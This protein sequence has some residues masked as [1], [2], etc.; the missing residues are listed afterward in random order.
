MRSNLATFSILTFFLV[1]VE[2]SLPQDQSPQTSVIHVEVVGLRSDKGEVYCALYSSAAGFPKDSRK[3]MQRTSS[4]ISSKN[5]A[6]EFS[7]IKPGT[8]AISAFHDENSN[9]K[10]DTNFLG[11]PREGLGASNDA[12]GHLGPPKFNAAAFQFSGGRLNLKI[13]INYF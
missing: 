2:D 5:A 1:S 3:A 10:L 12:K 8:Y 4:P 9:G 6:C 7:A 11:I 13:T